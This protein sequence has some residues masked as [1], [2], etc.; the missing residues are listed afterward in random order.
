MTPCQ[1]P[2]CDRESKKN[3]RW[4][5]CSRH[6]T[7]VPRLLRKLLRRKEGDIAEEHKILVLIK[8]DAVG[9]KWDKFTYTVRR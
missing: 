3:Y 9:L 5:F 8:M 7:C 6:W 1:F 4:W 2:D